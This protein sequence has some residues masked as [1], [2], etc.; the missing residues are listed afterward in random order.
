MANQAYDLPFARIGHDVTIYSG[1]RIIGAECISIGDSVIM[2]DFVMIMGGEETRIGSFV[3]VGAFSSIAGGG[4]ML[5]DDFA[6]LSGGVRVYTG[7]E[8]YLGGSL[9]GPSVPSPYRV[10]LRSFVKICKYAV[11]GANTVV[12]PGV[13]IG[14]GAVVG[15]N[16]L[17]KSDLP[18]W[19]INVGSP[20]RP[21]RERPRDHILELERQLR[22]ELYDSQGRYIAHEAREGTSRPAQNGGP[23]LHS[24]R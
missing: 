18:P 3:H 13:T 2:D 19:T 24:S 21:I 6:G 20:A 7:N 9:T 14:E 5:L 17:V 16:C 11:I 15:A 22:A 4:R 1:A 10:P 12:L 8:D 23:A